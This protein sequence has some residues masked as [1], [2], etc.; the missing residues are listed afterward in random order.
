MRLAV[1]AVAASILVLVPVTG[2]GA[3]S[4]TL[5]ATVGPGFSI[6]LSDAAGNPVKS[7][8]PGTYTITVE[9]RSAIHNFHLTGPGVDKAT[10]IEETGTF[11]WTVTFTSGR[12]VF[13]CDAH[14]TTMTGTFTAGSAASPPAVQP[15]AAQP[16]AA[17][18]AA[19]PVRLVGVVGPGR[20]IIVSL[21]GRRVTSV[22]AGKAVLV[23]TDRSAKD[24]FRLVGPGVNRAT[25]RAGTGKVT[26]RLTL[27]R[28]VYRYRSDATPALKGSF[29]A[30]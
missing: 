21:R 19:A 18:P 3:Q 7:L 30:V 22:P 23:V 17:A 6:R 25:S 8:D 12:Y 4:P 5:V 27:K 20:R 13:R 11:T 14:P 1:A 10:D 9:D 26:W 24:D 16:P 2:A 29:R 15:P 28:G